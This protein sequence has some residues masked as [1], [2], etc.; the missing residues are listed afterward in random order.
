MNL[1]MEN[2]EKHKRSIWKNYYM[3]QSFILLIIGLF[4]S[5]TNMTK[6][7]DDSIIEALIDSLNYHRENQ[8]GEKILFYVDTL[9][10]LGVEMPNV[11][12]EYAV[13]YAYMGNFDKGIQILKDSLS[14]S[15]KPQLLYNELGIKAIPI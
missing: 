1:I 9:K 7:N 15:T 14:T 11:A 5:C 3:K 2:N 13:A 4:C 12:L 8:D 6:T 10:S